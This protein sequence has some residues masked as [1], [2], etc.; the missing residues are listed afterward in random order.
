ML[1]VVVKKFDLLVEFLLKVVNLSF[2]LGA[3]FRNQ[4][5]VVRLAAVLQQ[6]LENLP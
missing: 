1:F 5:L 3:N 6:N 2:V 4:H